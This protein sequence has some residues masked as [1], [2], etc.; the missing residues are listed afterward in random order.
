MKRN[1]LLLSAIILGFVVI[2]NSVKRLFSLRDTSHKVEEA[3]EYLKEL[4][5]E[6]EKLKQ[7]FEYKKSNEF[8][9]AEIRNKLGLAKDGEAVV[10]LPNENDENWKLET[11]NWKLETP[12]WKKWRDLF[13]KG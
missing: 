10:I 1:L 4:R 12:N 6:Y 13:L 3:Q 2:T 7:E 8:A 9:E 11:G 5:L